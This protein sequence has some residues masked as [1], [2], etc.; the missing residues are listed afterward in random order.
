MPTAHIIDEAHRGVPDDE[1]YIKNVLRRFGKAQTQI[2]F[3]ATPKVETSLSQSPRKN[4]RRNLDSTEF[5]ATHHGGHA[6]T[7]RKSEKAELSA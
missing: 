5:E 6:I 1:V 2:F 3:A 7:K 4:G